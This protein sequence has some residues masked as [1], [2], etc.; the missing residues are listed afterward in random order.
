MVETKKH[1]IF[2][3]VY[4]LL[5]LALILPVATSSVEHAFS[6]L[7]LIKTSTRNKMGDQFLSDYLVSY[8]E[9][10][11]HQLFTILPI[12]YQFI[13]GGT[14]YRFACRLVGTAATPAMVLPPPVLAKRHIW[15]YENPTIHSFLVR[16][17]GYVVC[18]IPTGI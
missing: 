12:P 10:L 7:K 14:R 6:A 11:S 3:K 13:L 5:K 17:R 18:K 4:F 2:P 15:D 8:I 16:S 9:K 1:I